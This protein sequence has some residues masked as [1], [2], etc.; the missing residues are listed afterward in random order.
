ME[1]SWYWSC[2]TVRALRDNVHSLQPN[3]IFLSE[4]KYNDVVRIQSLS[5][6]LKF[7]NV[8]FVPAVGT[9]GGLLLLWDYSINLC[10][11]LSNESIVNCLVL[12]DPISLVWRLSFVYGP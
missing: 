10:I 5:S 4:V 6:L 7:P 3:V 11:I 12:N 9:T 1:L 2:A 8:Q